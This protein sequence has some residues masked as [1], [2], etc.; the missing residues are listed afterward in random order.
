MRP[1]KNVDLRRLAASSLYKR[2]T[3]NDLL[4]NDPRISGAVEAILPPSSRQRSQAPSKPELDA[5][6]KIANNKHF[7]ED[8]NAAILYFQSLAAQPVPEPPAPR[9]EEWTGFGS[10]G[11]F[12]SDSEDRGGDGS[13]SYRISEVDDGDEDETFD[14][15]GWES[16][17]VD[18]TTG[19]VIPSGLRQDPRYLQDSDSDE[20]SDDSDDAAIDLDLGEPPG[21]ESPDEAEGLLRANPRKGKAGDSVFLPSLSVGFIPGGHDPHDDYENIDID[22]PG[23]AQRKNRRGQ[24]ARRT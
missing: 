16:G 10:D 3:K 17:S 5:E 8:L 9:D 2:I 13:G 23:G 6:A 11:A 21:S 4:E 1:V 19:Q 7:Q 15:D 14:D 20:G 18:D 22:G 12:S 24:R